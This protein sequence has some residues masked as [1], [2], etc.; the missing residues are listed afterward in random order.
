MTVHHDDRPMR[1]ATPVVVTAVTGVI[2]V[3]AF[4]FSFANI[5]RLALLL[6]TPPPIAWLVGPGVDLSVVGLI[7]AV[8]YLA[9]RGVPASSL[10]GPR[11]LLF[12]S[13]ALTLGLNVAWPL[14]QGAYG[15][16]CFDAVMPGL[17]ICWAETGPGLLRAI[18][19]ARTAPPV[20]PVAATG[21]AAATPKAVAADDAESRPQAPDHVV[22][23]RAPANAAREQHP[24][25]PAPPAQ[26]V[27]AARRIADDH[28]ARTGQRLGVDGLRARLPVSGQLASDVLT[29]LH[30]A[31]EPAS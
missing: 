22:P 14:T 1:E 10:R 23:T 2:A 25:R 27:D 28:H 7:V 20:E 9:E 3:L 31:Q 5:R 30:T 17:L 8:R 12:A 15:A 26:L 4:T 16:A 24:D 11:R 6:G 13:G 29:H 19:A 18:H 21:A